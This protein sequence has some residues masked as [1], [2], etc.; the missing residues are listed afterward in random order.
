[1]LGDEARL[2]AGIPVHPTGAGRVE[3]RPSQVLPYLTWKTM[4]FFMHGAI[5]MFK[6]GKS[7]NQTIATKLETHYCVRYHCI[8]YV[9]INISF[10]LS[11]L[12]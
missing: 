12:A 3:V 1:M 4:D 9:Y 2:A 6:M 11:S 8:P 10:D 7:Q 5:V